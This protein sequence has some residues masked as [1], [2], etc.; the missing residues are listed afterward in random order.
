MIAFTS[1][2]LTPFVWIG[3][4][5][6]NQ[7]FNG[8]KQVRKKVSFSSSLIGSLFNLLPVLF[9]SDL[10]K[11]GISRGTKTSLILRGRWAGSESGTLKG[12]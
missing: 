10:L 2:T 9:T 8:N 7:P 6:D 3:A 5:E 4:M 12:S 11:Y 1:D